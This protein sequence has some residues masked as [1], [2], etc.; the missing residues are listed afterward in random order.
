MRDARTGHGFDLSLTVR[1][2]FLSFFLVFTFIAYAI[3]ERTT[4]ADNL[5]I[6]PKTS[7][8][9]VQPA[10]ILQ[11]TPTVNASSTSQPRN[12]TD[13]RV[14]QKQPTT[15]P[16]ATL[17]PSPTNSPSGYRDGTYT[18]I[19]ADAYYG[20]VTVEAVI[21]GGRLTD[22]QFLDYP[23]DRRTSQRI[24]SQAVPW[25][26]QEAIQSQEA[27][28]NIISG[29]TLTSEAFIQSLQSALNKAHA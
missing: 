7:P 1:K 27:N 14:A 11:P 18:G 15:Q 16:S 6:P 20:M 9:M 19:A 21:Q 2:F 17:E 5:D 10:S 26:K 3:H 22:V 8:E 29:A 28:V 13:G 24:N 12:R 4:S 25:L 23:R